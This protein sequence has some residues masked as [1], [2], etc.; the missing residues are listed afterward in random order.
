MVRA[1]Q[2]VARL[3]VIY[4]AEHSASCRVVS[5]EVEVREGD[6]VRWPGGSAPQRP[7]HLAAPAPAPPEAAASPPIARPPSA[8]EQPAERRTIWGGSL[9]L[10]WED[11]S[12]S[13]DEGEAY[14]FRQTTARLSLRGRNLGGKPLQLEVRARSAQVDR[15]RAA[16]TGAPESESR[17]RLY[18]LTLAWEPEHGRYRLAAGRMGASPYVGIGVL[19]GVHA[20]VAAGRRV[21]FGAFAGSQPDLADFGFES[22]G[23][24]YGAYARFHSALEPGSWTPFDLLLGGVREDGDLDV[25]REYALVE[26]RWRGDGRWSFHQRAEVDFNRGWREEV[27]GSTSQLSNLSLG[28]VAQLSSRRRLSLSYHRFQPYRTEQTRFVEDQLFDELW[29]QGLRAGLDLGTEGGLEFSLS[30]GLRSQEAGEDDTV[31]FGGGVRHS[32][33]PWRLSAGA[34]ALWY[35]GELAEGVLGSARLSRRLAAGHS[36]DLSL[37]SRAS[38]NAFLDSQSDLAWARLGFWAELPASL[39]AYGDYERR[40]G[41]G[42]DGALVVL[43]LGYRF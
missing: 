34:S 3:E 1:G 23:R 33:L 28:A 7:G 38:R 5:Q 41:D 11:W 21:H 2:V 18:E 22:L 29:R 30:A 40:S 20:E 19:D 17:D 39:F 4:V 12:E 43:G 32:Q 25:S 9:T 26:L 42:V 15:E 27:A 13:S 37:G 24:R 35:Q 8:Y 31:S 10:D 36:M 16:A 14:G 6:A